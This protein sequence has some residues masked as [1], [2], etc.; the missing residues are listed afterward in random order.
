MP[1][2]L[3]GVLYVLSKPIDGASQAINYFKS[4]GKV[5]KYISNNSTM[6]LDVF[7]ARL[8][9]MG[10]NSVTGDIVYPTL[11]IIAHLK[12][13]NFKKKVF[14]IGT[15]SMR[16]EFEESGLKLAEGGVSF[17]SSKT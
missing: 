3:V 10:I 5:V 15:S 4:S 14:L 6:K 11:A 17:K 1:T 12:S 9:N 16:E 13:L 2:F 7:N 8:N